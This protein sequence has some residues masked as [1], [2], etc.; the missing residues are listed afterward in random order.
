MASVSRVKS[1]QGGFVVRFGDRLAHRYPEIDVYGL[2]PTSE[3]SQ[4][5]HRE[6]ALLVIGHCRIDAARRQ[7]A[8]NAAVD[9]GNVD[10][11][12]DWPGS[13]SALVVDRDN[14]TA[15]ADL[16]GQFPLYYSLAGDEILIGSDPGLLAARHGRQF[17]TVAL[18][19]RICCPDAFPLWG[20]RSSYSGVHRLEGGTILRAGTRSPSVDSA[21]LPTPAADG[22]LC[23]GGARLRAALTDAVRSRCESVAVSTDFSGGH[24]SSAITFLAARHS[25]EPVAS[26]VYHHPLAAA[27]DLAHARRF[28][29]LDSRIKLT[30]VRGMP[31]TLPFAGFATSPRNGSSSGLPG[32]WLREPSPCAIVAQR[33]VLRLTAAAASGARLHLT[34]E[35]GDALLLVRPSYLAALARAREFRTLLRH[36]HGYARLRHAAPARL[37]WDTVRLAM[38]SP[39]RALDQLAADLIDS[40][41]AGNRSSEWPDLIAWWPPCGEAAAW[42]PSALRHRLAE[43]AA[44]PAT[45]RTVPEGIDPAT[46][47]AIVDLRKSGNVMD[48]LRNLAAPLGIQVHAPFLDGP[49]I[50]AA[51]AIPPLVRA[52]PWS[53]KPLLRAAM[54]GLVPGEVF[55]RRTKGDYTA[56]DYHG[57]RNAIAVLREYLRDS[58]LADLGVIEPGPVNVALDRMI[59]GM[60]VPLGPMNMLFAT[61]HWL[62][63]R[64][65]P[66]RGLRQYAEP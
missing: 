49:V 30:E 48:D 7:Q 11:L 25:P 50:R 15:Y 62:R 47:S 2:W 61:E 23:E 44:D 65:M 22:S 38:T 20:G 63:T 8:F 13:F 18:A 39:A 57:A 32:T 46:L 45:A 12:A 34:G 53:Y 17:D 41:A 1:R 37:V 59:A 16:S 21:R 42:L 55:D 6:K 26:V 5:W 3:F 14:V 51:L 60:A 40:T 27:D 29:T 66:D 24:D 10:H 43:I 4:H 19:A 58:R 36:C 28:A 56:E 9:E 52:D 35:G 54:T 33:S 64:E 31:R